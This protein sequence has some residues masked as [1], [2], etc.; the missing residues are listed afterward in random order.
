MEE[1]LRALGFTDIEVKVYL[2]LI[3][4]GPS[5][6]GLITQKSGVHRR[7]VYDAVERLI[8]KGLIGF[9]VRNNRK[10]FSAV[11]PHR[12]LEILDEKRNAVAD[13]LPP[14]EAKFTAVKEKRETLFFE[15]KAGVKN[16]FEDQLR[17]GK[18]LLIIGASLLGIDL[19]KFY[20]IWFDKRRIKK[21]M[22]VKILVSEKLRGKFL[23][24]IPLSEIRYLP[25]K[26]IGASSTNI[27]DDKVAIFR[28]DKKKP[29]VIV[30]DQPEI[31]D[32]YRRL[33][34]M[35]WDTGKH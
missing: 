22:K 34:Q 4:E 17:E 9:I 16:V 24:K 19:F 3:E 13:I 12:L 6:A 1:E 29:F 10:L 14:L 11:H 31:A 26:Y 21:K 33:Y 18:E 7:M 25:D 27:Y 15:G 5:H 20:F 30:I 28:W 23:Q 35:L 2:T 8:K 32:S